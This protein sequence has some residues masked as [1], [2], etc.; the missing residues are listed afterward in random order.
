MLPVRIHRKSIPNLNSEILT[1]EWCVQGR[2]NALD[3]RVS[4][5]VSLP[6]YPYHSSS[7]KRAS[8]ILCEISFLVTP[9]DILGRHRKAS[10]LT[11]TRL[12]TSYTAKLGL[13]LRGKCLS[14]LSMS[15]RQRLTLL[16]IQKNIK[17]CVMGESCGI[18]R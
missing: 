18:F 6:T 17:K 4:R 12:H 9:R 3:V 16:S 11:D 10:S 14:A 2:H 7:T 5:K 1:S 15:L 13:S 8:L